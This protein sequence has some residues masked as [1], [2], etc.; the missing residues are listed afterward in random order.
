MERLFILQSLVILP[1]TFYT[2]AAARQETLHKNVGLIVTFQG[3]PNAQD[4]Y[5]A[6]Q[7]GTVLQPVQ[8]CLAKTMATCGRLCNRLKCSFTCGVHLNNVSFILKT[9]GGISKTKYHIS[10]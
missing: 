9:Q 7:M 10:N 8:F 3:N 6:H 4:C 1:P 2:A 5:L